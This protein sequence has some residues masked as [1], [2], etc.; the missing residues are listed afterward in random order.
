MAAAHQGKLLPTAAASDR[1][2]GQLGGRNSCFHIEK[3]WDN[4]LVNANRQ[5]HAG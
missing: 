5:G 1:L 4:V 2:G 3:E